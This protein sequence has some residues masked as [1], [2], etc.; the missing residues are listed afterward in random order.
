MST[1]P[2]TIERTYNASVKKVWEAITDKDKMKQWYFDLATFKPEV[3]FEF[4]F[5]GKGSKGENYIHLCKVLEVIENKKISY[6]WTYQDYPGY[7]VV[8]FELFEEGKDKTRLKLTH[9][10]LE[11]FPG[12]G[13]FAPASFKAGWNELIGK[14]LK[15]FLEKQ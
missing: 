13:D 6:S 10:G 3:G 5:S 14:L 11:T 4:S 7:S 2:F 1:T 15:E 12:T 8:T 9:A